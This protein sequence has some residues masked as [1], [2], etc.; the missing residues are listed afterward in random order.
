MKKIWI[1]CLFLVGSASLL[2]FSPSKVLAAPQK[3]SWLPWGSSSKPSSQNSPSTNG[4]TDCSSVLD[5]AYKVLNEAS[6]YIKDNSKRVLN[7]AKGS[8]LYEK[9]IHASESIKKRSNT[10]FSSAQDAARNASK[11]IQDS[12]K[13]AVSYVENSEPYK[14]ASGAAKDAATSVKKNYNKAVN[15]V[16]NSEPYKAASGAV[17][18]AATSVKKNYNKA[19]SYL[20]SSGIL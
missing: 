4:A 15:Y 12:Y 1:L 2:T 8:A 3:G 6:G 17:K 13:D 16:E 7:D 19:V 9:L 20:Q 10:L 18:D 5:E 11:A 14:A